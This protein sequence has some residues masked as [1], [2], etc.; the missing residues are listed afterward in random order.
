MGCVLNAQTNVY[1]PKELASLTTDLDTDHFYYN[2]STDTLNCKLLTKN[3]YSSYLQEIYPSIINEYELTED[4]LNVL[5]SYTDSKSNECYM[6]TNLN[7]LSANFNDID[8]IYVNKL[9]SLIRGLVQ[10]DLK[11]IYYR[12]LT[13][14]DTEIQYY[15]DRKNE[16]Y[17]TTSFTSFT[18]DRL[19]IYSGNAILLLRTDTCDEK[20]KINLAN[21]W[22][23][24]T[25][26]DEKEALLAV[27]T[28]LKIL[29][30]HY[31][32]CKWE[33]EVELAED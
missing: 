2:Y 13:L 24:S 25:F 20:A 11:H 31:Y 3:P 8:W 30:V 18:I 14:T 15:L 1:L 6:K 17:Y 7:L 5:K 32:G 28:K 9:R 22:K 10:T 19:L 23:W 33:I 27:G 4:M 29:S 21:I 12:G 26:T 16:Y